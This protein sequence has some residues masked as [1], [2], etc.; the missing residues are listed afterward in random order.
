MENQTFYYVTFI[1]EMFGGWSSKSF[2]PPLKILL[3][4]NVYFNLH[5]FVCLFSNS[6]IYCYCYLGN[7]LYFN[8]SQVNYW[9]LGSFPA[10]LL[11]NFICVLICVI[12]L[13]VLYCSVVVA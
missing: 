11:E 6:G 8:F 4:T 5:A 1:Y 2:L 7:K 10:P 3:K 13:C 9:I 12:A